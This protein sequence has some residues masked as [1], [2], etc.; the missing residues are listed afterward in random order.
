LF[1]V[2]LILVKNALFS[3]QYLYLYIYRIDLQCLQIQE[4]PVMIDH[5]VSEHLPKD[6][7]AELCQRGVDEQLLLAQRFRQ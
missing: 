7:A 4:Q 5:S 3:E 1:V 6:V 2:K